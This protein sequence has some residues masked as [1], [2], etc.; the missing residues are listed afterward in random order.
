MKLLEMKNTI[1]EMKKIQRLDKA[2]EK[3]NKLEDTA[4]QSI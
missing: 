3:I 1:P 4:I 2:E